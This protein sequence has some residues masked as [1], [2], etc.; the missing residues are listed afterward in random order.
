MVIT[1]QTAHNTEERE[2]VGIDDQGSLYDA[3]ATKSKKRKNPTAAD[4]DREYANT[5]SEVP[6]DG[7]L[8]DE[9]LINIG[10]DNKYTR[11]PGCL[12]S[13]ATFFCFLS[14][15][16]SSRRALKMPSFQIVVGT[17]GIIGCTLAFVGVAFAIVSR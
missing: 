16:L 9:E 11:Y 10:L 8:S 6:E 4:W 7:G 3:E 13:H 17:C 2:I 12:L 5:S 14:F 15:L 1:L